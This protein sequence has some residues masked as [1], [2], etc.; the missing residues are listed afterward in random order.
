MQQFTYVIQDELG[1]HARPA[2]MA[3]KVAA[4][5][6]SSTKMLVGSKTIDLKRIMAVMS[7]GVKHGAEITVVVEGEDEAEAAAALETFFK[8]NL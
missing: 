3:V 2:G 4:K 6:K 1:L 8:E 5:Y 7:S